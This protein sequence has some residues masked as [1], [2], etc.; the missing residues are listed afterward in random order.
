MGMK[1]SSV[2]EKLLELIDALTSFK[3]EIEDIGCF[4]PG[5][6]EPVIKRFRLTADNVEDA[7]DYT[8]VNNCNVL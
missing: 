6:F 3:V 8:N 5:V 2:S 7:A 4:E 1:K